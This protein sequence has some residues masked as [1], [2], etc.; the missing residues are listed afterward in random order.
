MKPPTITLQAV[1]TREGL[2][3]VRDAIDALLEG[4]GHSDASPPQM[5][6]QARADAKVGQVWARVGPNIKRF[7]ATAAQLTADGRGFTMNDIAVDLGRDPKTVRSWHRNLGRT[8]RLVDAEIPEPPLLEHRW[9]G[10]QNVYRLPEPIRN[11]ILARDM[12]PFDRHH[13]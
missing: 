12:D 7:L 4:V 10:Q 5:T 3:E 9:E 2:L 11:A 6:L 13:A 1:L 8:L